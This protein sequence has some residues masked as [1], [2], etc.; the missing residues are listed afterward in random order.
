MENTSERTAS[1]GFCKHHSIPGAHEVESTAPSP[2]WPALYRSD[3]PSGLPGPASF[4]LR[5]CSCC[6]P[7]LNAPPQ[8]CT[9]GSASSTGPCFP[10]RQGR[11]RQ[12]H[13]DG[14][15]DRGKQATAGHVKG[16]RICRKG[17]LMRP[18]LARPPGGGADAQGQAPAVFAGPGLA[19]W[20]RH[21]GKLKHHQV[22][23][24]CKQGAASL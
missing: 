13:T 16:G 22:H 10:A 18:G 6:P 8:R 5:G 17:P 21:T 9:A 3:L 2:S 7:H 20:E 23:S 11:P 14:L 24:A 12:G 1:E 4:Q 15:A 19:E